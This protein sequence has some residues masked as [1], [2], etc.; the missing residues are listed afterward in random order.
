VHLAPQSFKAVPQSGQRLTVMIAS[1]TGISQ[2]L[3][4]DRTDVLST[5]EMQT[6]WTH[7]PYY[8]VGIYLPGSPNRSSHHT[9]ATSDW[10]STVTGYGWGIWPIWFG[11]QASCVNN[12][13]IHHRISTDVATAASQGSQQADAAYDAATNL[14]LDGSVLYFDLEPYDTQNATCSAS[15]RAYI[16]AFVEE[17]KE[18]GAS[19][20]GAY[21]DV[22]AVPGDFNSSS[23]KPDDVWVANNSGH[24]A[25]VW[26][27]GAGALGTIKNA[28]LTDD[29]WSNHERIHQYMIDSPTVPNYEAWGD[30]NSYRID[31]DIVDTTIYPSQGAKDMSSLTYTSANYSDSSPSWMLDIA[32]GEN[33]GQTSPAFTQG[34]AVGVYAPNPLSADTNGFVWPADTVLSYENDPLDYPVT[35]AIGTND[36]G[37]VV[38]FYQDIEDSGITNH[39]FIWT[40]NG[41][42]ALDVPDA[43]QTQ[44][45]SINDAEWIAG[46]FIDQDGNSHCVL[47][48]PIGGSYTNDSFTQ[49]DEPGGTCFTAAVNGIGQIVG[50]YTASDGSTVPFI[51]DAETSSP[52]VNPV[53]LPS[54]GDTVVWSMNNNQVIVGWDDA[55]S[56]AIIPPETYDWLD[57]DPSS[58]FSGVNDDLE[59]VGGDSEGGFVVDVP[60]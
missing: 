18:D 17:A 29:L 58:G 32:N 33:N 52:G 55:G 31:D 26:N 40:A 9:Y 38:G 22:F 30:A 54:S 6:W 36:L 51:E 14:D 44:L 13:N 23:P 5:T 7:S 59:F 56:I 25:T 49:F 15:V 39:G 20:V 21:G 28:A 46:W 53:L 43:Q 2:Q 57:T 16:G 34:T 45:Y 10:I 47:I 41:F 8:D 37:Q 19:Y 27:L 4:F 12:T 3:A 48:R 60:H 35:E 42:T 24:R 11:L 1:S 50:D